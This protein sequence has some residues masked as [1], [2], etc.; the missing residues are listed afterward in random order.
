MRNEKGHRSAMPRAPHDKPVLI[1]AG[2]DAPDIF[3]TGAVGAFVNNGNFHITLV[4]R[5]GDYGH[6]PNQLTD[7]AIGRLV[8]PLPAT[9][10]MARFLGDCLETIK[11]QAAVDTNVSRRLQ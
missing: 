2:L 8:M 9:E 11:R 7:V 4:A 6:L 5:R 1:A 3:A 10:Q